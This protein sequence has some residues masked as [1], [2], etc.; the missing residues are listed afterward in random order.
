MAASGRHARHE[1]MRSHR[2]M[3]WNMDD[4]THAIPRA[5]QYHHRV[6][7]VL[8]KGTLVP[9][10]FNRFEGK[11]V[12]HAPGCGL[13]AFPRALLSASLRSASRPLGLFPLQLTALT[14]PRKTHVT[15]VPHC[16]PRRGLQSRGSPGVQRP[17]TRPHGVPGSRG[18][19]DSEAGRRQR[20]TWQRSQRRRC[21]CIRCRC[22]CRCMLRRAMS[23]PLPAICSDLPSAPPPPL[24]PTRRR[25]WPGVRHS[26]V[27]TPPRCR[28]SPRVTR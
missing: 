1:S 23:P 6:R 20:Y 11:W 9:G 25:G 14:P 15:G 24:M 16:R 4:C 7:V 19:S 13:G 12:V 18:Q 22:R 3:A 8:G 5:P 10:W 21:R 17:S 26:A 27:A 28:G 2:E